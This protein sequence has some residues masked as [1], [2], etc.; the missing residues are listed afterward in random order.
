[1]DSRPSACSRF[2]GRDTAGCNPA[3]PLRTVIIVFSATRLAMAPAAM[4]I[5]WPIRPVRDDR[6]RLPGAAAEITPIA[7]AGKL[8]VALEAHPQ[9]LGRHP[10]HRDRHRRHLAQPAQPPAHGAPSPPDG[11]VAQHCTLTA[12]TRS[13]WCPVVAR[14]TRVFD[15]TPYQLTRRPR[16]ACVI[17]PDQDPRAHLRWSAGKTDGSV[18]QVSGRY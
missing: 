4:P 1:M 8:A 9:A 14:T 16:P 2:S 13:S 18:R 5:G 17:R 15:F 3:A 10:R 6:C 7:G 11:Q 12:Y